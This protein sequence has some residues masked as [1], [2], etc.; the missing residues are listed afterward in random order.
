MNYRMFPFFFFGLCPATSR[1][2]VPWPG[3]ESVPLA[4]K[5]RSPNHWTARELPPCFF[6]PFIFISWRLI[7]LQYCSVFCHTLTWIRLLYISF[8]FFL[9][10]CLFKH[11]VKFLS[12]LFPFSLL[13]YYN[14]WYNLD[15]RLLADKWFAGKVDPW[16]VQELGAPIL[17]AV[18]DPHINFWFLKNLTRSLTY[19]I[20][21]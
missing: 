17:Q 5:V 6:F 3:I 11:F 12:R 10:G 9:L 4:V 19:N 18:E 8:F 20:N 2:L 21:S 14:F 13:S 16:T 1:I 15:I 7:T